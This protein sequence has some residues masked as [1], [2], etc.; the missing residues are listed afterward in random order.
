MVKKKEELTDIEALDE[1]LQMEG[2]YDIYEQLTRKDSKYF[3]LF[4]PLEFCQ[5]FDRTVD[6]IGENKAKP[7]TVSR[8]L[9]KDLT[10]HNGKTLTDKQC[11]FFYDKLLWWFEN[12]LNDKQIKVCCREIKKL[13]DNLDV[14]YDEGGTSRRKDEFEKAL[15]HLETLPTYEEKIAYLIQE[16]TKSEQ[17]EN[18]LTWTFDGEKS[19]A[20]KCALEIEK[21]RQLK[22]LNTKSKQNADSTKKHQD[23]TLDRA[24]LAL[25]YL[26]THAKANCHNTEKAKFIS[27]L[28]GYSEKQIAQKL[29]KLH[30][31]EDENYTAYQRDMKIISQYFAKLGLINIT[32]QIK[33]DLK[34]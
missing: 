23:L 6:Y 18:E 14:Y 33:N 9:E 15:E 25:N 5:V 8:Y 24:T 12:E 16:K 7:L 21:L 4:E 1:F 3:E 17:A 34:E 22:Q 31:K 19:F 29:S 30:K 11:H 28:T 13:Q 26:L 20:E 27:F 2:Y 32:N 10:L